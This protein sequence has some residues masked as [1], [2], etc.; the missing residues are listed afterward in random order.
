MLTCNRI[1]LNSKPGPYCKRVLPE[2]LILCSVN[3]T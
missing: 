1:D 3:A 2:A